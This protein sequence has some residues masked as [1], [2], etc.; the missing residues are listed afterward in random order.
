MKLKQRYQ[1]VGN[2]LSRFC[3]RVRYGAAAWPPVTTA[4]G[5][6]RRSASPASASRSLPYSPDGLKQ[7]VPGTV[8]RL[9]HGEQRLVGQDGEQVMD[10]VNRDRADGADLL[11]RLKRRPGEGGQ[12]TQQRLLGVIEQVQLQSTAARSVWWRGSAV[13]LPMVG[14]RKGNRVLQGRYWRA[15]LVFVCGVDRQPPR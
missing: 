15:P 11:G 1:E 5:L 6:G 2:R 10:V 7:A 3:C 9:S 14:S 13:R 12:A 8:L 4:A